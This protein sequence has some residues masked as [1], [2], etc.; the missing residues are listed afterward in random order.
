MHT[1]EAQQIHEASI[2]LL[3]DP[4]IRLEHD[5]IVARLLEAG[6]RPGARAQVVRIPV[7]LIDECLERAPSRLALADR[8]GKPH[9]ASADSPSLVWS[10]PGMNIWRNGRYRPFLSSDMADMTRLYNRL[11]QVDGVFGFSMD[12]VPA[13]ARD[14]V[15]L[16]IMAQ[17]TTKHIRAFCFTPK[18]AD[19]MQEMR[20]VVAP[21]AWFSVG[22]TAHGPLRWT[23]LALSI[24]ERTA[25]AGIPTT[26]NGEPMAGASGPVTLAGAA[27][28]GNAE[29]LAGLVVNQVLEPGRPCIYNLGLAHVFDMASALAVT[30]GPE[31]HI[32]ADASAAMGRFYDLPSC[33]WVSTEAHRPGSHAAS[34]KAIGFLA[35]LQS[36]VSVVWGVGQL[37]SEISCS[38]AQAVIDNEVL[39][40]VRRMLRGMEVNAERLAV[41]VTREVGI[42]GEYISHPHTLNHWREE[43]L[44]PGL[45]PRQTREA[46]QAQGARD[47]EAIAEERAEAL[48]SETPDDLLPPDVSRELARL[49]KRFLDSL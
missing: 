22:F 2:E 10:V 28:V 6:A 9:E 5:G 34:E 41:D 16:R 47:L 40:Y 49:E 15:G 13:P 42:G 14:V 48:I 39:A 25:G 17:N 45:F 26:I 7:E 18:G 33:S 20:R 29:I 3:S 46:W 19:V 23:H 4:G 44:R 30:G 1:Q 32:L 21:Q 37:E 11:D 43:I 27:A 24:F 8:R 35:H 31:N 38:P 36:G 12:D